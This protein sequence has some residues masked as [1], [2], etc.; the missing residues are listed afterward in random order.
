VTVVR[1]FE[2]DDAGACAAIVVATPL[3]QPTGRSAEQWAAL[4]TGAARDD[5]VLV[6]DDG[7]PI[8]FAWVDLRGGFG[9]S[10]YLRMIAVAPTRR[11]TGLGMMLLEAFE[12]LAIAQ[13][14][15]AFLLV[16]DGNRDAQRFYERHGYTVVGRIADYP[17]AGAVELLLRKRLTVRL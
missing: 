11:S 5:V 1:S 4:L 6:L 9:R 3:W 17:T 2:P 13:G 15:D 14:P 7:A 16:S 12:R 8:G 10:A